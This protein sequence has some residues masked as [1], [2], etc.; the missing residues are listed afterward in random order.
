MIIIG[1]VQNKG[2]ELC[3]GWW[4][5]LATC[6]PGAR[7][8]KPR[9]SRAKRAR[10]SGEAAREERVAKPQSPRGFSALARLY[11][12]A[13]KTAMLRRLTCHRYYFKL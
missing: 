13:T 10:T 3:V 5:F 7:A 11:Y 4:S 6:H 2:D 9:N 12:L 8:A 1:T